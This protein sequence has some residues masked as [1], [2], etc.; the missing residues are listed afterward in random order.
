MALWIVTGGASG[1]GLQIA[2]DLAERGSE[3]LV[4]DIMPPPADSGLEHAILDLTQVEFILQAAAAIQ[5]PVQCFVHCAGVFLQ[6]SVAHEDV[7]EA[8]LRSFQIH[9][10]AFVTAVHALL[11]RFAGEGASAIAITSA[12]MDVVYPA[13]LAYGASKAALQ[14]SIIQLAVELGPRGIRVNGVAPGA[15]AT[16]M[17]RHLWQDPAFAA[18]RSRHIPLGHQAEADAVSRAVQFLGSAEAGYVTG[19]ILWVDGGVRHGIFNK[20]V[21][22]FVDSARS[23]K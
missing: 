22:E 23:R 2:R 19:E 14:R 15:I 13:T 9:A 3:V 18:E 6:T 17:T 8:M 11:D 10:L 1:I 5:R 4:W 21:H 7:A 16:P 12:A 20:T